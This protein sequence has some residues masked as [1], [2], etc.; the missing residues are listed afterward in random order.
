MVVN[1]VFFMDKIVARAK[2][3][4]LQKHQGQKYGR[5]NYSVHLERVAEILQTLGFNEPLTQAAAWLHDTLE[6]TQTTYEELETN[7]GIEIAYAVWAISSPESQDRITQI[8]TVLSR[9]M[10]SEI[11][12]I[13][14]LAD[15]IA[16]TEAS[17]A[18]NPKLYEM[19]AREYPL[20]VQHLYQPKN[21]RLLP[22]WER[23]KAASNPETEADRGYH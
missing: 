12:L 1:R 17:K 5:Y 14:K 3:F 23:L 6:D 19:Y 7:F 2:E 10:S 13:V 21:K 20:F 4:A 15:R 9:V 11:G 16:N 22:L 18:N 8:K